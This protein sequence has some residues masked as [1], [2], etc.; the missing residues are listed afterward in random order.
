MQARSAVLSLPSAA[1]AGCPGCFFAL[2]PD[3]QTTW[4]L[5][6][7]DPGWMCSES[8]KQTCNTLNVAQGQELGLFLLKQHNEASADQ[9]I[10]TLK[11]KIIKR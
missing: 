7:A 4:C 10:K 8:G 3:T 5:K 11:N 1:R 9:Y 6:T 2:D